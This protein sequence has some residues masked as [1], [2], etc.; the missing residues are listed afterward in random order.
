VIRDPAW[1]LRLRGWRSGAR[2]DLRQSAIV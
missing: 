2:H 1:L